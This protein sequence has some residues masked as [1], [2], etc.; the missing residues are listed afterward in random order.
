MQEP[1]YVASLA[2]TAAEL[3]SV[4][5]CLTERESTILRLMYGLDDQVERP[6]AEVAKVLRVSC[7]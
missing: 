1:A 5:L 7:C 6:R 2:S 3:H 4:L